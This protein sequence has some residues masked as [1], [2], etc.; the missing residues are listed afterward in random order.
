[1]IQVRQH[2]RDPGKSL[3][4]QVV[5]AAKT[6]KLSIRA[7]LL[8]R[9]EIVNDSR[10]ISCIIESADDYYCGHG[11]TPEQAMIDLF[12]KLGAI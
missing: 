7:V 1:M 6:A 10:E 9:F 8:L 3:G 2:A 4:A 5:A 12:G 11:Q